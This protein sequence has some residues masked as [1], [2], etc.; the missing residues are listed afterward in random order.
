VIKGLLAFVLLISTSAGIFATS[1]ED[2]K[3]KAATFDG[4]ELR[5]IGPALMS[6]RIA[7][8][9]VHPEDRS[10]W[11][12]AVG[13][14]G[15][16]KTV[17]AGTTWTPIFDKQASYSIGCITIDPNRH[18]VIWVGTG[19][20]VGG[21][22][23]GYGDGIY[24][25]LDG[26]KTWKN[27][28]LRAS[29]HIGN[30]LV[31]PRDSNVVYAAS[32]GPLWSPGGDRGLFK[33]T[34]GGET[35]TNILSAGEWTGANEVHFDPRDPDI[36]YCALHQKH[37]TVAALVNGGPESG[38]HK[39]YDGGATWRKLEN[40]LPKGD[41]GKIGL[42]V[43]PID[44]DI[45]YA[46]IELGRNDGGF[47][48][49][50][51]AGG[52]WE[53]RSDYHSG[54]TG[55]HYYQEIF[56]S[57]HRIDRVYQMDPRL[58]WTEDGGKTFTQ[59]GERYKHG[60]NHAMAFDPDDPDYLL[61][62]SDGGIYESFDLGKHWKF[63]ANLPI[64][65]FYKVAIDYDE[66]FYNVY[67]GTQDNN[68]QGGPS[69]TMN[70]NGILNSD[71]FITLFADGH[72]PAVDPTNPD[73]IYSEW[74]QGNLVRYDR[75]TGEL[76]YI[77]PQAEPGDPAERFNWDAPILISPH[78]PK[79]LYYASQRV[80]RS[81]DRGDSWQPIS[82]DLSRGRD[83]LLI[84]HMGRVQSI[85][86]VW[87]LFAM[88]NFG[89]V[90][91][92][93]ES[94]KVA[95]LVYAG[96]DDGLI[97]VTEDGGENW[98]KIEVKSLPDVPEYA[99][100]NDIKAD[101][102]DP[103]TVYVVLDNHKYGDF[104]PYIYKST[105]RGKKWT[106]I[107]GNLPDRHICWRIV[108]D[109]VNP[110]LL[111]LGTEMGI[112]FT[113]DGGKRWIELNGGVPTISFRD[114]AIQTRENDL[115]AAS[116]GRGFFILD[117]Y[118]PLRAVSET[119]LGEE[120]TLFPVRDALWYIERRPLGRTEKATQGSGFFTAPNPPFGAVFT[121]YLSEGY[122]SRAEQRRKRE[123]KLAEEGEDTPYPGWDSLREED[124]EEEPAVI[125]T[126]TDAAGTVVRRIEGP[127]KKGFHRVAWDLR[128]AP[129][130]AHSENAGGGFGGSSWMAAPGT[131]RVSLAKRIDGVLTELGS[132]E[133]FTVRSIVEPTLEGAD[134]EEMTAFTSDFAKL[135]GVY[136]AA[137]QVLEQLEA[138]LKAIKATLARS[139]A[140]AALHT[141]THELGKALYEV[142]EA[143]FGNQQKNRM[144]EPTAAA[145][146]KRMSTVA[147]GAQYSTYGPTPTHRR[148][149]EIAETELA[150]VRARLNEML[151]ETLPALENELEEA[152]VPWTP[153]RLVPD[154]E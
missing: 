85:D 77:Q 67:G 120:A 100:I 16:W 70:V 2:T 109:H 94:P 128:Y 50:E 54:G 43:S 18:E 65:Q 135:Q 75:K 22:H 104:K 124:L 116:F 66:P 107:T 46:T 153:G 86:G 69:R 139:S 47:W 131:Y 13:S 40:G 44:P 99:F 36:L 88:S 32:Q 130:T 3:L 115:V 34:D 119:M 73:I 143:L 21:R 148:S 89:T 133:R 6:G 103:D 1:E 80:W 138:R 140:P 95:D 129:Q 7:D 101:L 112:F 24:K 137:T 74:Q 151:R 39:S 83:R 25:S 61:V 111:F 55:P 106:S 122:Q 105:N 90:T 76:V 38:I 102:H 81:D 149:F 110:E 11:Y 31:D 5:N 117:D 12:V 118:S 91:S 150:E 79:R 37:R 56:A 78:D 20:N 126:V 4:L 45:L 93:A 17:N 114:L 98:R 92:L 64:T 152:G 68:T 26:G 35:W 136:T 141:R 127:V 8:F 154:P 42:A 62:G 49:S 53:K 134:P 60:D 84:P 52:S 97:Q 14:G 29:E 15:V 30:I 33:T 10:V 41:M 145:I 147:L 132:P 19:E 63:V 57:P 23:V 82:A 146:S 144:G 96:T 51:D 59:V 125:L 71:W 121:Y 9:A 48:R 58:H 142:R 72:Q 28:G 123:K 113:I 108:Q 27:M 87:D